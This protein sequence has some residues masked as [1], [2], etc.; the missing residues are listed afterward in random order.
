M[1]LSRLGLPATLTIL[2]S[3]VPVI[4]PVPMRAAISIRE[5]ADLSTGVALATQTPSCTFMGNSRGVSSPAWRISFKLG[6]G[7]LGMKNATPALNSCGLPSSPALIVGG[8]KAM[9]GF[10]RNRSSLLTGIA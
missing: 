10:V 5:A 8:V 4:I 9:S 7:G 3:V 6:L 1:L 2:F